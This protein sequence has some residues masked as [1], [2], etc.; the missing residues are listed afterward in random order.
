MP[1]ITPL[2]IAI[3]GN[4][5]NVLHRVGSNVYAYEILKSLE[6]ITREQQIS[7]T[8]LLSS[9]KLPD[10]PPSRKGWRYQVIKPRFLWTQLAAPLYLFFNQHRFDVFF[11]PG[12]YAP[13]ICPIPYVSTVMDL[14]FLQFPDQF[15]QRDLLQ[16]KEW[17][18][19]SVKNADKVVAISEFTK[20][21]IV[22]QY[23]KKAEDVVVAYP[24]VSTQKTE[25][26]EYEISKILKKFKITH[27]YLLYVGTLQ[28]RKNLLKLIA[29][30][31]RVQRVIAATQRSVKV[32]SK[33]ELKQVH[34]FNDIQLVLAGK[35]GWLADD[36][37][38]RVQNSHI[39]DHIILTNYIDDKTKAA[40]Y[41][42]AA[43]SVLIG[44]HEGFGIPPLESLMYG[45][46]PVVANTTSL[47]EVVGK[48]G[49]QVN[50]NNV[51]AIADGLLNVLLL[52]AKERGRLRNEGRTQLRNFS[53]DESA[54]IILETLHTV[55]DGQKKT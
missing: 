7:V 24:A 4:E 46:I 12:H 30:F 2:T 9:P 35:V 29:A 31:E 20:N 1:K 40:L 38:E 47:P 34:S 49:I 6:K 25:V 14:A 54:R 21:D 45:A 33:Y 37:L 36:I 5:A 18:K 13:R 53:W 16:L 41:Q 48:A 3:D 22:T 10:L 17:T 39:S 44:T 55:V 8:V 50:P 52:S 32:R 27:P 15:K 23:H 51:A 26:K 43:G 19:Y 28:P 42:A 11:T